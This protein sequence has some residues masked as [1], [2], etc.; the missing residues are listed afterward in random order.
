MVFQGHE[1]SSISNGGNLP[2]FS[3]VCLFVAAWTAVG[4]FDQCPDLWTMRT[5][6]GFFLASMQPASG[7]EPASIIFSNYRAETLPLDQPHFGWPKCEICIT[8]IAYFIFSKCK[9]FSGSGRARTSLTSTISERGRR[10][11]PLGH[12]ALF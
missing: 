9:S 2:I 4:Q 1:P 6:F 10:L 3:L 7:L 11:R 5:V 8:Y 12:S